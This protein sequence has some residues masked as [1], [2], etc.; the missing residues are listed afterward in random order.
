MT[1]DEPETTEAQ[2][3]TAEIPANSAKKRTRKKG[4]SRKR[5]T[6]GSSVKGNAKLGSSPAAYPRHAIDKC[7]RIP[8]AII[9]QNAGKDCTETEAA[10]FIGVGMG[11]AFRL[12]VSSCIKYS[13]LERPATGRIMP[14]DLAK[15]IVRPQNPEEELRSLRQSIINAPCI[16]DVYSHY[17]GE[18]LPDDISSSRMP[19]SISSGFLKIKL[20]SSL[21]F[22]S[23]RSMLEN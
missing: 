13:L 6:R 7:L 16:S 8:K 23:S 9:E 18:N 17:R 12:E 11:G 1:A 21:T 5:G 4:R 10:G 20:L 22:S 2:A 14:S 3:S 19:W 15:K